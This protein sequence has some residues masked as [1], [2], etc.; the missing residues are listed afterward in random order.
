MAAKK[1]QVNEVFETMKQETR[2]RMAQ[3]GL[4]DDH[5]TSN[6]LNGIVD[7]LTPDTAAEDSA[8]A[9]EPVEVPEPKA[10]ATPK[11]EAPAM[12]A[13]PVIE[14]RP[15]TEE[16]RLT[17][18]MEQMQMHARAGSEQAL[19]A[20]LTEI[21][22]VPKP[23]DALMTFSM[24]TVGQFTRRY[25]ILDVDGAAYRKAWEVFKERTQSTDATRFMDLIFHI[26]NTDMPRLHRNVDWVPLN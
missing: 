26:L 21:L 18:E 2:E 4:F 7:D 23:R 11:A 19:I 1:K 20:E 5:P 10:P 3:Q 8:E 22:K 15:D 14:A 17:T 24:Y 9:S 25:F 12:P 13:E 16:A 6:P